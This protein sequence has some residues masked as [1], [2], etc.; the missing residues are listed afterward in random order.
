[1]KYHVIAAVIFLLVGASI[2]LL[3]DVKFSIL[4]I[5]TLFLQDL[6]YLFYNI[7]YQDVAV[8]ITCELLLGQNVFKFQ[9]RL[10]INKVSKHIV[11]SKYINNKRQIITVRCLCVINIKCE[12]KI[13]SSYGTVPITVL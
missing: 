1:M 10:C 9:P 5:Y 12:L 13:S 6:K 11:V 3:A 8:K 2:S 7:L 4:I